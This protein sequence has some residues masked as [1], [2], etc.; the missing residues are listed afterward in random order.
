MWLNRAVKVLYSF[1][2]VFVAI[3]AICSSNLDVTALP[4]AV[5]V[6]IVVI[7]FLVFVVLSVPVFRQTSGK[8]IKSMFGILKGHLKLCAAVF[9]LLMIIYQILLIATIRADPGF[10]ASNV[11]ALIRYSFGN[12][13]YSVSESYISTYWNNQ[14]YYLVLY[15][16]SKITGGPYVAVWDLFNLA[17]I[18]ISIVLTALAAN[19]KYGRDYGFTTLFFGGLLLGFSPIVLVPYTDTIVLPFVSAGLLLLAFYKPELSIARHLVMGVLIGCMIGLAYLMKLSSIIPFIA[20]VL[21][22]CL[23]VFPSLLRFAKTKG[24]E[25]NIEEENHKSRKAHEDQPLQEQSVP[26]G[27]TKTAI[28]VKTGS[29]VLVCILA[30]VS[31][32]SVFEMYTEKQ[33]VFINDKENRFPITHYIMMGMSKPNGSYS[34]SD[35]VATDEA[36][37]YD[38]K[39]AFNLSVIK[40]RLEDFGLSGYLKFLVKKF[41][42]NT[43]DGTFYFNREG[44]SPQYKNLESQGWLEQGLAKLYFTDGDYFSVFSFYSQLVWVFAVFL[45]ICSFRRNDAFTCMLRLAVIGALVFL[46]LFEGGRS[47]YLVQFLPVFCM[48]CSLGLSALVKTHHSTESTPDKIEDE[49]DLQ[50]MEEAKNRDKIKIVTGRTGGAVKTCD[51]PPIFSTLSWFFFCLYT[52]LKECLC[53]TTK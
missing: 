24:L 42:L 26:L 18:D 25:I 19:K 43:A 33:S 45:L 28:L 29:L 36:G 52:P 48:L 13:N 1:L 31:I 53:Q 14:F 50:G 46:L 9:L 22:F 11:L 21:V 16:I 37:N 34:V 27:D 51:S 17:C 41:T 38:Q 30:F 10:D 8:L 2:M 47:R 7:V 20:A 39:V 5:F 4:P 32:T 23:W 40:T 3:G 12:I 35:V 15:A 6:S 44:Q 49:I